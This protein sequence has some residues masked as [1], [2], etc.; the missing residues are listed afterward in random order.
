MGVLGFE[1][2]NAFSEAKEGRNASGG[3]IAGD[4]GVEDG[5]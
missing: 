2:I 1:G 5:E 3:D 4:S